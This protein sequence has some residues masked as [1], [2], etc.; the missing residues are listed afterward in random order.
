MFIYI[1]VQPVINSSMSTTVF[2]MF[3]LGVLLN[4]MVMVV[5]CLFWAGA[6]CH[7]QF[8][9]SYSWPPQ[10]YMKWCTWSE[11]L[12]A[13]LSL[14]AC[15]I[16]CNVNFCHDSD[17]ISSGYLCLISFSDSICFSF[18]AWKWFTDLMIVPAAKSLPG[19]ALINYF[20]LLV[21]L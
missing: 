18:L 15:A 12:N 21:Y 3:W 8:A 5:K 17:R 14:V 10:H 19:R 1:I 4:N 20:K 9:V 11:K 7:H 13:W 16:S 6:Y 2:K